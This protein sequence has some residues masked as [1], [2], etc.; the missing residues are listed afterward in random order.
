M[1]VD[2]YIHVI[3]CMK[4]QGHKSCV[5][6]H[7]M[8]TCTS[9]FSVPVMKSTFFHDVRASVIYMIHENT[10]YNAVKICLQQS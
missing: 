6:I 7:L 9:Q 4:T 2:T 10:C 8:S 5:F 3:G 1:R